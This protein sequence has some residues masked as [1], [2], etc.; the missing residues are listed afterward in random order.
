MSI[1]E[2]RG[3]YPNLFPWKDTS[4]AVVA[5]VHTNLNT[6]SKY[7]DLLPPGVLHV[8]TGSVSALL[9]IVDTDEGPCMYVGPSFTF[10]ETVVEGYP[11]TRLT[12]ED[13]QERLGTDPAPLPPEWTNDFRLPS[14]HPAVYLSW[15]T[16]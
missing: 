14:M 5:D 3:W 7:P 13:W 12:D 4:P 10:Y 9:F 8:A 15:P 11:P 6:D 16:E 1:E 2:W